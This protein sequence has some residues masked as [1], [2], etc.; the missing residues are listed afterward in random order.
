M[1]ALVRGVMARSIFSG[2]M[3]WSASTSAKTGVAPS[4]TIA[5]VEATKELGGVMTSS[6]GPMPPTFMA[7]ISASVPE[8]SATAS[9]APQ[10]SASRLLER[11]K[12][13]VGADERAAQQ[14][15]LEDAAEGPRAAPAPGPEGSRRECRAWPSH[16]P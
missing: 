2:S 1:I 6:P 10:Y 4:W 8:L 11:G 7:S 16:A 5:A 15:F 3:F 13:V 12:L 9:A 14:D